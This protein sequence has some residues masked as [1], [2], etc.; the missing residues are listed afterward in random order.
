MPASPYI[1]SACTSMHI[2]DRAEQQDRVALSQHPLYDGMAF[3]VLADGM[4][5]RTGGGLAADQ[6]VKTCT[7]LFKEYR[8]NES[9]PALMEQCVKESNA[10]IKLLSLSEE[11]DPH[12]TLVALLVQA[13]RCDWVHVG[14]SR[15]YVFR[16]SLLKTMTVDHSFVMESVSQG[17][18]TPQQAAHHID[19]NMLTSALGMQ[20]TPKFTLGHMAQAQ[21]GDVFLL[22]S[23]GLWTYF[24]PSELSRILSNMDPKSACET[25]TA[26]ARERAGGRGDNLS[27][28]VLKILEAT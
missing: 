2:G 17:T 8:N 16:H 23:D 18:L 22:V 10:L 19:K 24:E 4:G 21:I 26:Q 1:I 11:K 15:L 28:I 27:I 7:Q 5:G 3:A 25:L 9:V 12:C 14:D 20:H 6:A 13:G